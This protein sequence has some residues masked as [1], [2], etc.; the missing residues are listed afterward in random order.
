MYIAVPAAHGVHL[1]CEPQLSGRRPVL[2]G[3]GASVTGIF[4]I[5]PARQEGAFFGG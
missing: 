5:V 2:F 1:W 3:A 4:F